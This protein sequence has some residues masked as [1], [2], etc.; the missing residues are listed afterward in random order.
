VDDWLK[1]LPSLT[2]LVITLFFTPKLTRFLRGQVLQRY[3][4]LFT[5]DEQ[6]R[7]VLQIAADWHLQIAASADFILFFPSWWTGVALLPYALELQGL[8]AFLFLIV[9]LA[10][11]IRP[12]FTAP[13]VRS[14]SHFIVV[15][16]VTFGLTQKPIFIPTS[17][18]SYME[19]CFFSIY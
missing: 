19:L 16:R 10:Y 18:L 4:G 15:H 6:I 13:L 17:S 9:G 14:A 5:S 2:S 11:I 7:T 8:G 3:S 1:L 12:I